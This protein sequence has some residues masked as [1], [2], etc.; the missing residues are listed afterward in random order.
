MPIAAVIFDLDGTLLD[1]E[2]SLRSFAR[3]QFEKMKYELRPATAD[4]YKDRFIEIDDNG[5]RWKDEVYQVLVNEFAIKEIGWE[6]LL[7]DYIQ[8]FRRHC[9]PYAGT[10]Q[11][12]S[13]LRDKGLAL[14]IITNGRF[15]F[16]MHSVEALGLQAMFDFVLVSEHEGVRKPDPEIFRRALDRLG[17]APEQTIY[18][19]DHPEND[20][21]AAKRVGMKAIWRPTRYFTTCPDAD[22]VCHDMNDLPDLVRQF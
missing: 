19:G 8:T 7:A 10:A 1:R 6:T 15:P 9:I 13:R 22:A 4:A 2:Q 20:V 21:R 5:R 17:V 11:A 14:A 12:L 18:I 3:A 16:H